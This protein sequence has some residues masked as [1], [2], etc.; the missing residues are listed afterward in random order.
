MD[1]ETIL[2]AKKFSGSADVSA[3]KRYKE[4]AEAAASLAQQSVQ[5]YSDVLEGVSELEDGLES[6]ESRVATLEQEGGTHG[7]GGISI[8]GNYGDEVRIAQD[9]AL[10]AGIRPIQKLLSVKVPNDVTTD[11]T[12][13]SWLT[14]SSGAVTGF[15]ITED[16]NGKTIDSYNH[17]HFI[18]TISNVINYITAQKNVA[19]TM[20]YDMDYTEA[21]AVEKRERE[22]MYFQIPYGSVRQIKADV[23]VNRAG[24]ACIHLEHGTGTKAMNV[25]PGGTVTDMGTRYQEQMTSDHVKAVSF[26]LLTGTLTPNTDIMLWKA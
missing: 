21:T 19:S 16:E 6:L 9:G 1:A 13:V 22:G 7:G 20:I 15:V 8:T 10:Y 4:A 5:D 14:N 18:M 24:V 17:D 2:I 23:C 12:D 26:V 11:S 25:F 3:A